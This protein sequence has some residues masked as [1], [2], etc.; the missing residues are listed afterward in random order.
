VPSP[1]TIENGALHP[2]I[3][4]EREPPAVRHILESLPDWVGN[5]EAI[6]NYVEAAAGSD[7]GSVLCVQ[8]GDVVGVALTHR[9]F[10]WSAELHLIGVS[11]HA[12]SRAFYRAAGLLPIE[13][14]SN[15]DRPGPRLIL[16]RHLR[17]EKVQ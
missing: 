16:V 4:R 10:P 9:H 14:H 3:I 13:K 2:Q 1:S 12:Q 7:F 15:L 5:P 8:S 11:P 6:D 17:A